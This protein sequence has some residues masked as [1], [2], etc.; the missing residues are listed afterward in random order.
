[1]V[2]TPLYMAP[3]IFQ[4]R[5]LSGAADVYSFGL[6][7]FALFLEEEPFYQ[8]KDVEDN[9]KFWEQKIKFQLRYPEGSP[10][11]LQDFIMRLTSSDPD[12]RPTFPEIVKEDQLY[13]AVEFVGDDKFRSIW[14]ELQQGGREKVHIVEFVYKFY[15]KYRIKPGEFERVKSSLAYKIFNL[16]M[17]PYENFINEAGFVRFI[18]VFGPLEDESEKFMKRAETLLKMKSFWGYLGEKE[19]NT[20]LSNS[21]HGKSYLIRFS[22]AKGLKGKLTI[23]Y[24]PEKDSYKHYRFPYSKLEEIESNVIAQGY[25]SGIKNMENLDV[26]SP[27]FIFKED[28]RDQLLTNITGLEGVQQQWLDLTI[29]LE[30]DK[31]LEDLV[32]AVPEQKKD[33]RKRTKEPKGKRDKKKGG[34]KKDSKKKKRV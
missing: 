28:V 25:K 3:E 27:H 7:L 26:V 15:E 23:T 32:K 14:D 31:T 30:K 19:A 29:T 22:V 9:E 13:E 6:V 34:G 12:A 21:S 10:E 8:L 1:M 18:N 4:Q 33:S 5:S 2:G 16:I 20:V 24:S 11:R 17:Q